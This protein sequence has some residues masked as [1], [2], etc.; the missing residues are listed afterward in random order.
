MIFDFERIAVQQCK[1]I[2]L[3]VSVGESA[4]PWLV[5]WYSKFSKN[6]IEASQ[7]R[8]LV[9]FREV[10]N[11][12][13]GEIF[14]KYFA[15]GYLDI[16][17]IGTIWQDCICRSELKFDQHIFTLDLRRAKWRIISFDQAVKEGRRQPY[18]FH[19]YPL[20]YIR[21]KNNLIEFRIEGGGVLIVPCVEYFTRCY[22]SSA[23][24]R[25]RLT[26]Y[27]FSREA[28]EFYLPIQEGNDDKSWKVKLPPRLN[29]GDAVMLAHAMYEN[30]A[31]YAIKLIYA[32]LESIYENDADSADEEIENKEV[33][34]NVDKKA[35]KKAPGF[36]EV[37]PWQSGLALIKVAGL[38]FDEGRSFLALRVLKHSDPYG[39]EI[40]RQLNKRDENG[41]STAGEKG[42][43][44]YLP[45]RKVLKQLP[46]IIDLTNYG[47]PN[48]NGPT[49]DIEDRDFVLGQHRIV[50]NVPDGSKIEMQPRGYVGS[51]ISKFSNGEPFGS[52][53]D[54]G[55]A[56]I[57]RTDILESQGNVLDM[58]KALLFYKDKYPDIITKVEWYTGTKFSEEVAPLL[59]PFNSFNTD[60]VAA[61]VQDWVFIG[62][63]SLGRR[64]GAL[65]VRMCIRNKKVYFLEIE[66][67]NVSEYSIGKSTQET[68]PGMVFTLDNDQYFE[69][70]ISQTLGNIRYVLGRLS[71]LSVEC[72]GI[73]FVFRH[74]VS[75]DNQINCQSTVKWALKQVGQ[76]LTD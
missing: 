14:Y 3:D 18:P 15:A 61:N 20:K 7:P 21:D 76:K 31:Q 73:Y 19:L 33:S 67:E 75:K 74:R 39:P 46:P 1:P 72:P 47:A 8:N 10:R 68:Y 65:I 59:V 34:T 30:Y 16:L 48:G 29:R 55:I 60:D 69:A 23:E 24:L 43:G 70:W 5:W 57:F 35:E 71:N 22:G 37:W 51:N 49:I 45:P 64:R 53:K 56:N 58:W 50:I 54:A 11:K 63:P 38:W 52:D 28:K 42:E 25:R 41:S 9:A 40:F 13:Y 27:R 36:I 4:N 62:S 2:R 44:P 12:G 66:R 32:G 17:R 6:P 26:L